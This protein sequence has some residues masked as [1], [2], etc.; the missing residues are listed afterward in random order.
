MGEIFLC[1]ECRQRLDLATD[2][3]AIPNRATARSKSQRVYAHARCVEGKVT[4][5]S[6][7]RKMSDMELHRRL[8]EHLEA[9]IAGLDDETLRRLGLQRIEERGEAEADPRGPR[10]G[11]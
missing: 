2:E 11:R 5:L 10:G 7:I 1:E 3:Y 6:E 9:D 4:L 8:Q